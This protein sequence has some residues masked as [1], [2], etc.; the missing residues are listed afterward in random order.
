MPDNIKD[1]I[2]QII[3]SNANIHIEYGEEKDL[4]LRTEGYTVE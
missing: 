2:I 4:E 3:D 1:I